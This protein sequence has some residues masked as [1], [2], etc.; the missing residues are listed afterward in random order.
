MVVRKRP[1]DLIV[2]GFWFMGLL[3]FQL[4]IMSFGEEINPVTVICFL[5]LTS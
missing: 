4:I 3:S 2:M 5:V 1:D